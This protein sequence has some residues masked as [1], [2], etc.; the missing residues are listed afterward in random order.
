M[1]R[2]FDFNLEVVAGDDHTISMTWKTA[3]GAAVDVSGWSVYY[4][5]ESSDSAVSDTITVAPAAVTYSDSG[6][7]TV[8]TFNIP[9]VNTATDITAGF[10]KQEVAVLR[11]TLIE[12]VAKGTLTVTERLTAVV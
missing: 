3:A 10:Y 4:K 6:T 1:G 9:L 2:Y 12:T 5:A 7:G 8:D 11:S